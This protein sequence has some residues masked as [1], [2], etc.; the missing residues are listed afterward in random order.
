MVGQQMIMEER[1]RSRY[2]QQ[3][4]ISHPRTRARHSRLT[5]S[6]MMFSIFKPLLAM[7]NALR[8][9]LRLPE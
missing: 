1:T 6:S 7:G 9:R 4:V 5:S 8:T 2:G 3:A